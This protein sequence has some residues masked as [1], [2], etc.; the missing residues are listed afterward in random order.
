MLAMHH[1]GHFDGT[2]ACP[3]PKDA[4]CPTNVERQTIKEWKCEDIAVQGLLSPRLLDRIFIQLI[5]HK[6]AK[7]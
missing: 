7:G 3:T 1:W 5:D 2:H 6:T 4:A